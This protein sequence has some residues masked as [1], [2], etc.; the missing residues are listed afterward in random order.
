MQGLLDRPYMKGRVNYGLTFD[1]RNQ[2]HWEDTGINTNEEVASGETAID[3]TPDA[4]SA[5]PVGTT[6]RIDSEPMS[7]TATGN[8]ITVIRKHAVTHSTATDI[9]K[10]VNSCVLWLPGQDDAQS[11]TIRDR[12]GNG[13]DGSLTNITWERISS[14]LWV[15]VFNGSS[16]HIDFGNDASLG[17]QTGQGASWIQWVFLTGLGVNNS[18]FNKRE[19][20]NAANVESRIASSNKPAL[21]IQDGSQNTTLTADTALLISTWYFIV[22]TYDRTDMRA[23]RNG[24]LD[25]TPAAH[26]NEIPVTANNLFYGTRADGGGDA[27]AAKIGLPRNLN[28]PLTA[29]Q[30]AGIYNQERHLF[31]V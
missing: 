31:G 8:T 25:C 12:S 27:L 2:T 11:S 28:L 26:T 18:L 22:F 21:I 4:T 30:T 24:V 1:P 16:S 15:T 14:G 29:T 3:V 13:N 6:I 20:F 9:Y 7:V 5:I 23:Y 10:K 17:L 19:T